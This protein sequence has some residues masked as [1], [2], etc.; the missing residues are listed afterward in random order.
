VKDPV[1]RG[2]RVLWLAWWAVDGSVNERLRPLLCKGTDKSLAVRD[3]WR[4]FPDLRV[5]CVYCVCVWRNG[6]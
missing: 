4:G 6:G 5:Y 2:R 3:V 1:A